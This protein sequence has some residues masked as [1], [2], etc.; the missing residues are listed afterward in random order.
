VVRKFLLA[1][2]I[3]WS[4]LASPALYTIEPDDYPANAQIIFPGVVLET[5]ISSL[6]V[7]TDVWSTE[8]GANFA[9][10][11]VRSFGS[12]HGGHA[13][14][15]KF[16]SPISYF[17]IDLVNDDEG[18][19]SDTATLLAYDS[20]DNLINWPGY[21]EVPAEPW[22]AFKT[23]E[24]SGAGIVRVV[25]YSGEWVGLD[26]MRFIDSAPLQ[27]AE[28]AILALFGIGLAGLGFS[29]RKRAAN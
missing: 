21:F 22:P 11:G 19:G 6:F 8:L 25:L 3:G 12:F 15:A 28:P 9:S 2:L 13:F 7:I 14:V 1:A 24:T 20:N 23:M 10:T 26:N 18:L 17:A 29:R 5:H 27:V 16:N 4:E